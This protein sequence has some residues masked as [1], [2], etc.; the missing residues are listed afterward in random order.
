M[1]RKNLKGS[2]IILN[3]KEIIVV[4]IDSFSS[5]GCDGRARFEIECQT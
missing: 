4:D 5:S 3:L 2:D 1:N